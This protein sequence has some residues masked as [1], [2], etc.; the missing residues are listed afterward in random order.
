MIDNI[1]PF[2]IFNKGW[3]LLTSGT[4]DDHNSMTISW[5]E[6]GTLWRK[7]VVTVYVKPCRYTHE[8][9]EQNDYFVLSFFK[10]EC[11]KALGIMGSKSGREIDKDKLS[12]LS[13]ISHNNVTIYKEAYMTLVCKKIYQNDLKIDNIPLQE[14]DTYYQEEAPHTMYI[15]EVVE[16]VK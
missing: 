2:D 10:D 9:M 15:G 4:I 7:S 8:F 16:V 14:I 6:M 11:K 1:N 5:G 3:A 13:P 12:G